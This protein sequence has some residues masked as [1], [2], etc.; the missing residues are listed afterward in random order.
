MKYTTF[1]LKNIVSYYVN[2]LT[3]TSKSQVPLKHSYM[4]QH[5]LY[6][7]FFQFCCF[8]MLLTRRLFQKQ[9]L[10]H[11]CK[12]EISVGLHI[13]KGNKQYHLFPLIF[14]E[15]FMMRTSRYYA[16]VVSAFSDQYIS[17]HYLQ[18]SVLHQNQLQ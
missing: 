16:L 8:N 7:L 15:I 18:L 5:Y 13:E 6:H 17:L 11:I 2:F 9:E 3:W 10:P 12:K 14:N 4:K 1:Y